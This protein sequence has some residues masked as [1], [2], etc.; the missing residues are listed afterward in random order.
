MDEARRKKLFGAIISGKRPVRNAKD[1][2][3][4][5]TSV[6]DNPD[7]LLCLTKLCETADTMLTVRQV[8]MVDFSSENLNGYISQF[9]LYFAVE[10]LRQIAAGSLLLDLFVGILKPDLLWQSYRQAARANELNQD[11]VYAFGTLIWN[12]LVLS[13]P[14]MELVAHLDI[15][16]TAQEL[17]QLQL[18][19]RAE[20]PIVQSVAHRIEDAVENSTLTGRTPREG[21]FRPGGRHDNDFE[22]FRK[23]AIFPTK[24]ELRSHEPPFILTM[25]NIKTVS[26]GVRVEAHLDNQFRLLREDML[27][28]VRDD[29][30]ARLSDKQRRRGG[31]HLRGLQLSGIHFGVGNRI[32]PATMIL[33]CFDPF[34]KRLP[35][36]ET[37]RR[38][39][40]VEN[41]S[42]LKHQSVGCIVAAGQV[43]GFGTID[44]D[45]SFL[46][47]DPPKL[48]LR[49]AST[50]APQSILASFKLKRPDEMEFVAVETPFFAYEPVLKR[51]QQ[52]PS[53]PLAEFILDLE[54]NSHEKSPFGLSDLAENIR[55]L[56]GHDIC[57]IINA[58]G[59]ITLD[60]AQTESLVA[61]LTKPVCQIQ[62]PPGIYISAHS[63][64]IGLTRVEQER[65]SPSLEPF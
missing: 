35:P 61:G 50:S 63:K 42:I 60:H 56:K 37:E 16:A 59:P 2:E 30:E 14:S 26:P 12:L 38:K 11:G 1:A 34:F 32:K 17:L 57:H 58:K 49:F 23:I 45:E 33:R 54:R 4:F 65:E 44:R 8:L 29:I 18:L 15:K 62:G 25:E 47:K 6:K 41:K 24:A 10:K 19:Q 3:L 51:L 64:G 27:A 7:R 55:V 31:F 9:I 46:A 21:D 36:D 39:Y 5:V 43:V 22:N 40:F 28:E 52:M 20:S 48:L 53:L 13:S